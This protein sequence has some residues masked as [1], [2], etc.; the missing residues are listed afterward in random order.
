MITI[1]YIILL[2]LDSFSIDWNVLWINKYR[3]MK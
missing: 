2:Q 3:L 1:H